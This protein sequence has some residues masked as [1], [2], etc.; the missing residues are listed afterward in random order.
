MNQEVT[1]HIEEA[2]NEI[3]SLFVKAATRIEALKPGEKIPA[4]ALA[5]DLARNIIQA[6]GKPMTGPQLYPTLKVL[7]KGYPGV[8]IAR[9]AHG[10]IK[11]LPVATAPT[12]QPTADAE[13]GQ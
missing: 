2:L 11:R 7:F 5:E 10:G 4:T 13:D 9:G 6:D 3:R 1:Q 12:A 8:E